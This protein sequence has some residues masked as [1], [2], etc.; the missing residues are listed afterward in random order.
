MK[1]SLRSK[2]ALLTILII[3][4]VTA[5]VLVVTY[6][7]F[8]SSIESI[9]NRVSQ[10]V[11]ETLY[12]QLSNNV[13]SLNKLLVEELTNPFY[14]YDIETIYRTLKSVA[15]QPTVEKVTL[16]DEK[17][18]VVHDGIEEIPSYGEIYPYPAHCTDRSAQDLLIT[19]GDH[20][21]IASH[22]IYIGKDKLGGIAVEVSSKNVEQ[23]LLD[24]Q[25]LFEN[26]RKQDFHTFFTNIFLGAFIVLVFALIIVWLFAEQLA[27]PIELLSKHAKRVGKG[28]YKQSL[29]I[30]RDDEIGDLIKSFEQM[31]IDLST[32][33]VSLE[34]L[35]EQ[36]AEKEKAEKQQNMLED[37]LK[38]AQ[39]MEGIGQLAAGIAHDLNNIL[40]GIVTYPQLLLANLPED[41]ELRR[42]LQ[43][44][45]QSGDRAAMIVQ[46]MLTLAHSSNTQHEKHLTPKNY[47]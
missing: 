40:G 38:R 27:Q 3:G 8:R 32:S 6:S 15:V 45:Q 43:A 12:L 19:K 2:L 46:D 23:S 14:L 33:T 42:P 25:S 21:I 11:S 17:C 7:T 22:L 35:R 29:K 16:F 37:Q 26:K 13:A 34:A 39:R 24:L 31:R 5:V 18:K 9:S 4:V 28:D 44:I 1:L 36:I 47:Y 10:D 20:S 41:S 30:D